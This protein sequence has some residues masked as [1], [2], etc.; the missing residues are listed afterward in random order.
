VSA[1]TQNPE[2]V[3]EAV[4]Q[5]DAVDVVELAET[6]EEGI[7]AAYEQAA[8]APEATAL[9]VVLDEEQARGVQLRADFA[10][11]FAEAISRG[12]DPLAG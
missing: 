6:V 5:S 10:K 2:A 12:E 1:V 11:P 4:G 8:G 9:A 7:A 3:S